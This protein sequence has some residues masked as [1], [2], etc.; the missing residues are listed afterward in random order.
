MKRFVFDSADTDNVSKMG[1]GEW[2]LN[3][4]HQIGCSKLVVSNIIIPHT[5]YN[6]NESNNEFI[7]TKIDHSITKTKIPIQYMNYNDIV[8]FI[9]DDMNITFDKKTFKFTFNFEGVFIGPVVP[10]VSIQFTTSY[11]IFG[12][13]K[14][15]IYPIVLSTPLIS[16]NVSDLNSIPAIYIRC[17]QIHSKFVYNNYR[18]SILHRLPVDKPFGQ[19][20]TYQNNSTDMY[21]I[22]E[23]IGYLQFSLTDHK[24]QHINMNGA[25]WK[26]EMVLID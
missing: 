24:G 5:F 11:K 7:T 15:I 20:I 12:F 19:L 25:D 8:S 4:N 21:V 6:I 1:V 18:T 16:T 10:I 17:N 22:Q 9:V 13:E 23:N 14:N 2:S 26:I 3:L